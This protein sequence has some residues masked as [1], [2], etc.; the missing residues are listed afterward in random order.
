VPVT[1]YESYRDAGVWKR[2]DT[3]EDLAEQIGVPADNLKATVER[4]NGFA[5]SGV[6]EDFHR[7]ESGYDKFFAQGDGPNPNLV[8][9]EQ[10][11][12]QAMAYNISDLGTKGGLL[13]DTSARVLRED[14]SVIPG[15]YAAGNTMAAMSGQTYPGPGVPIGSSMI[16]SY[17][18][19]LDMID[20]AE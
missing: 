1:D 11:P 10:G 18:A 6:D 8:P 3:L 12:F 2:A 7:G 13:T 16:F 4:F 14:G 5:A 20:Q 15:V 9:I 17:L 19:V